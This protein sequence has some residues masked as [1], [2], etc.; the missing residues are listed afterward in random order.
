[1]DTQ[2]EILGAVGS[3]TDPAASYFEAVLGLKGATAAEIE[4]RRELEN[5]LSAGVLRWNRSERLSDQPATPEDG[6]ANMNGEL[7][8]VKNRKKV[9]H[10]CAEG[11]R[12]GGE[13]SIISG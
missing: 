11:E 12:A 4:G 1:M 5:G 7:E 10:G 8:L 3:S 9:V 13:G 6:R 2:K